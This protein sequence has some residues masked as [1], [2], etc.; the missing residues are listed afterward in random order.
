MGSHQ[1]YDVYRMF[2]IPFLYKYRY[3]VGYYLVILL[4]LY[5]LQPILLPRMF[6]RLLENTSIKGKVQKKDVQMLCLILVMVAVLGYLKNKIEAFL[7][8][9]QFQWTRHELYTKLLQLLELRVH[10]VRVGEFMTLVNYLPREIRYLTENIINM[11]PV[12]IG[13]VFL[14]LYTLYIHRRAGLLFGVGLLFSVYMIGF[15]PM[16][17]KLARQSYER[18]SCIMK[19]NAKITE[20][21]QQLDHIYMNN[22]AEH[23]IVEN[24]MREET[25]Q[26]VFEGSVNTSNLITVILFVWNVL[27]TIGVLMMVYSADRSRHKSEFRSYA[28]VFGFFMVM[29]WNNLFRFMVYI[30][31]SQSVSVFHDHFM[32][33]IRTEEKD[34]DGLVDFTMTTDAT[35]VFKKVSYRYS[36]TSPLILHDLDWVIPQ[37]SHWVLMGPSGRGKSTLLK[38]ILRFFQPTEGEID[39][40]GR[41]IDAY[42]VGSIREH[43]C[44]VNQDTMLFEKSIYE[45]ILFGNDPSVVTREEVIRVFQA[46]NLLR[47]FA[48]GNETPDQILDR[49]CGIDGRN[50]SKGQQKIVITARSL[51]RK[52]KTCIYLMDEPLASLDRVTQ[53]SVLRW[54]A[55]TIPD[56]TVICTTHI[57]DHSLFSDF[58]MFRLL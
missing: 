16:S 38:L 41:P 8:T 51:F 57:T 52:N 42:S 1:L 46:Y 23:K 45:N 36:E 26:D 21:V 32:S 5:F 10:S 56:K 11:M 47:V 49:S 24:A 43:I 50:L 53:A 31:A 55:E 28:F 7:T 14:W 34:R 54:I 22:Q 2:Y 40:G 30:M 35:L 20:D 29:L 44:C 27:L 9:R 3:Q 25:L 6:N 13:T 37:G 48:L 17:R 39:L 58:Q 18:A 4:I 12:L 33:M 15:S 19:N